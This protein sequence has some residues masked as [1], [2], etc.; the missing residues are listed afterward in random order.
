MTIEGCARAL[1]V[2]VELH[3]L[4]APVDELLRRIAARAVAGEPGAVPIGRELLGSYL[5]YF[6]APGPAELA[7]FDQPVNRAA[8]PPSR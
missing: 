1:G 4:T 2:P 5:P 8:G 6:E 3:Y 7:L